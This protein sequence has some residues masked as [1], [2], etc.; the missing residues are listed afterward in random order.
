LPPIKESIENIFIFFGGS[1]PFNLTSLTLKAL[2][3]N[4]LSYLNADVVVG[5]NN[6]YRSSIVEQALVRPKTKIYGPLPHLADLMLR[7]DLAIGAGGTTTWERLALGLPSLVITIA[8]N[9]VPISRELNN[10][11]YIRLIGNAEDIDSSHIRNAL[12]DEIKM[13]NSPKRHL[14]RRLLC[15]GGG[16]LRVGDELFNSFDIL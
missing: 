15:D 5:S 13:P 16:V 10:L 11:G 4:E 2:S 3:C 1:D 8:E 9:Q 7:A 14:E 12:Q 6:C